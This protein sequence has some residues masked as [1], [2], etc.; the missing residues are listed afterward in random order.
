M[1][2]EAAA[3]AID[4]KDVAAAPYAVQ[5]AVPAVG[6]NVVVLVV[7]PPFDMWNTMAEDAALVDMPST[8]ALLAPM[9]LIEAFES[10]AK[11]LARLIHSFRNHDPLNR[12]F[13]LVEAAE[14]LTWEETGMPS[15]EHC[16]T[17][18]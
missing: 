12:G 13:V 5:L 11:R 2:Q 6:K 15:T 8:V 17:P 4:T 1:A 7:Y 3:P 16:R 14:I 18:R 10:Q 9:C